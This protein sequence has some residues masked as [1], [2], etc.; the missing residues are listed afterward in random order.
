M[1]ARFCAAS[2]PD[3]HSVSLL[4]GG[5]RQRVQFGP[6][7]APSKGSGR[8]AVPFNL[9]AKAMLK[10]IVIALALLGASQAQAATRSYF[11]PSDEGVRIGACLS[12]SA[13]CGKV[14][15]DAFCKKQGFTESILFAR[16]TVASTRLIDTG[17]LCESGQ[18]EALKRVKCFQAQEQALR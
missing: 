13:G 5:G 2:K 12:G 6:D 15:A 7:Y 16:E 11:S 8:H 14:A 4:L 3:T 18:C 10:A 17:Q 1:S 9:K